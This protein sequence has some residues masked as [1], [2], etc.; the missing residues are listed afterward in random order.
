MEKAIEAYN[1]IIK[2]LEIHPPELPDIATY[3]DD[4]A[5]H[6]S[7]T[8]TDCITERI[9]SVREA[10]DSAVSIAY[11]IAFDERIIGLSCTV[12]KPGDTDTYIEVRMSKEVDGRIDDVKIRHALYIFFSE[13]QVILK[14]DLPI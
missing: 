9:R 8:Y 5:H 14:Q 13:F 4:I 7:T 3:I 10:K 6:I 11:V 1:E 12:L 2:R